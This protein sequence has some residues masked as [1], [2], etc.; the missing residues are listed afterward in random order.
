MEQAGFLLDG[1][2][3]ATCN[4]SHIREDIMR[5]AELRALERYGISEF[6]ETIY[7][8]DGIWDVRATSS[9]NWRMVG[10]GKNIDRL[11]EHGV[12]TV[13][14]DYRSPS[15][16]SLRGFQPILATTREPVPLIVAIP[17]FEPFRPCIP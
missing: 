3:I 9:L 17:R 15:S 14:E 8:G 12:E 10:I 13:F 5:R 7:F 16:D 6:E 11:R 4:D 1:V 2:P